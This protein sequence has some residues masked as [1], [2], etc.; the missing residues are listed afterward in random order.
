MARWIRR[1]GATIG[2]VILGV[3]GGSA[4]LSPPGAGESLAR[5]HG[6]PW[7]AVVAHRGLSGLAPEETLPAYVLA[8]GVGADYLELDLQRTADGALIALHDDTVDRTTDVA[9]VFPDRAGRGPDAFTLDELRRLDAGSWFNEAKP[10]YARQA[11]VGLRVATLDEIVAVAGER[12]PEAGG[13][14]LYI[15]TKE[16]ARY[17]G[18]EAEL[19]AALTARGWLRDG[20]PVRP[21]AVI[22]QSFEPESL[23]LLAA[24]APGVPRVLLVDE[25][26][27]DEQGYAHWVGVATELGAGMGPVGYLAWPWHTGAAHRAGRLVHPYTIDLPWQMRL[28]TWFGADGMFTNRPDLLLATWG[29]ATRASVDAVL[30][31]H[32][33]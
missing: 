5:T 9:A 1:I 23:R 13:P 26:M 14:G 6:I 7:R 31:E 24:A 11:W 17:P 12:G 33:W 21:G 27:G 8:R 4:A 10:E 25:E 3:A 22:F 20:A 32:G 19:V 16:P 30:A 29:R 18:I 15:E 28:M 2:V